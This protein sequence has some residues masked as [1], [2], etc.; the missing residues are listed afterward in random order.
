MI[1]SFKCCDTEALYQGERVA[2]FA[3]IE[4]VAL[5]KLR[6]LEIAVRL[7]DLRSPGTFWNRLKAIARASTVSASTTNGGYALCDVMGMRA[8]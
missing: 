3:N 8:M 6:Q 4:R 5:R 2:R 7:Q 1:E